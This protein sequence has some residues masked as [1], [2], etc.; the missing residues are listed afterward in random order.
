M[1]GHTTVESVLGPMGH[2]IADLRLLLKHVLGMKPWLVDPKVIRLPWQQ[3]EHD[4]TQRKIDSKELVFGVIKSDGFVDVHPPVRR[5]VDE[6][7]AALKRQ[8]HGV[9]Y[10]VESE[11]IRHKMTDL[12]HLQVIEWEPPAHAEAFQILVSSSAEIISL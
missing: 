2:S 8:G 5:A 1:E 7:V 9:K 6:A 3:H 11:S 10:P 12:I 4:D